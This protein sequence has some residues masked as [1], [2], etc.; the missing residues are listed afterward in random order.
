[1]DDAAESVCGYCRGAGRY[2]GPTHDR[3]GRPREPVM[4][5]CEYCNGAGVLRDGR[6]L[7]PRDSREPI[8]D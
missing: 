1:M 8:S 3:D 2:P 4:V 5:W 7:L 6:K